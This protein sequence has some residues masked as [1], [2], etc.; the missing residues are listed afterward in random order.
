M[1][2]LLILL[3]SLC[4][5]FTSF[6]SSCLSWLH[7]NQIGLMLFVDGRGAG[8]NIR[9]PS[10]TFFREFPTILLTRA[11]WFF[12]HRIGRPPKL[13]YVVFRLEWSRLIIVAMIAGFTCHQT[14]R[15]TK[16]IIV[17]MITSGL[18]CHRTEGPPEWARPQSQPAS[19]LI[20]LWRHHY[21]HV[22]LNLM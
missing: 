18:T 3:K 20:A 5:Q 10:Q 16:L 22:D 8:A 7:H 9:W 11:G 12:G 14:G 4:L 15:P 13:M 19:V 2:E 21:D 17:T 6:V 1:L